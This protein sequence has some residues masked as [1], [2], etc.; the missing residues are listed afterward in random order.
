[1]KNKKQLYKKKWQKG[2]ITSLGNRYIISTGAL[3][4]QAE[5]WSFMFCLLF[6]EGVGGRADCCHKAHSF[7]EPAAYFLVDENSS[8]IFQF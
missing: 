8:A 2:I 1:M 4:S 7:M 3:K 5:V 6:G